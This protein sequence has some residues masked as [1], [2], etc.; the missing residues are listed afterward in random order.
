MPARRLVG[1]LRLK[2]WFWLAT[3]LL[4]ACGCHAEG[5][6]NTTCHMTTGQCFCRPG[7]IGK[8]CSQCD[9]S[10]KY[11]GIEKYCT[12]SFDK[13]A[14][15]YKI[16]NE[17]YDSNSMRELG[18][19]LPR[20]ND[21]KCLYLWTRQWNVLR[22]W[23]HSTLVNLNPIHDMHHCNGCHSYVINAT[24]RRHCK[25]SLRGKNPDAIAVTYSWH[26]SLSITSRTQ[27]PICCKWRID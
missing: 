22:H 15:S 17:Y 5:A 21:V 2:P 16:E 13:V 12:V 20:L 14:F 3:Y 26:A 19:S 18:S 23:R 11:G 7:V 25:W 8:T 4:S 1:Y 24:Q 27:Q 10:T 6:I 9:V